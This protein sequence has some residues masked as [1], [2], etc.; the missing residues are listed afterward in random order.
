M[1][2]VSLQFDYLLFL[3]VAALYYFRGRQETILFLALLISSWALAMALKP[4]FAVPRPEDVRFVTSA[5]GYS[6]PSGHSLMSFA[7]AV[8]L[9]PRAG[10]FKLLVWV[11]AVTISLSRIF[12][13]VHFPSDVL[14]G[15]LI[16]CMVG[17]FW[18]YVEK[19]LIKFGFL[20][21]NLESKEERK[22]EIF[23]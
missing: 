7:S 21:G 9:S 10:K 8:F 12:I 18:L 2:F 19:M 15:A 4:V 20:K 13:G 22:D 6:M 14:A 11:F 3:I 16:G 23:D 5:T 17:L 1:M